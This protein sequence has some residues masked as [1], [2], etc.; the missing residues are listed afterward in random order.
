MSSIPAPKRASSRRSLTTRLP[1]HDG[2]SEPLAV[3]MPG[4]KGKGRAASI[5][6]AEFASRGIERKPLSPK[7]LARRAL[8][9]RK[10]ILKPYNPEETQNYTQGA[11]V[12]QEADEDEDDDDEDENE[13]QFRNMPGESTTM[14]IL[15]RVSFAAHAHVRMF[16]TAHANTL[17]QSQSS[18]TSSVG[19]LPPSSPVLS[20]SNVFDEPAQT[21]TPASSSTRRRSSL[22]HQSATAAEQRPPLRRSRRSSIADFGS[23]GSADMSME[24]E[25]GDTTDF[26]GPP[27]TIHSSL[28]DELPESSLLG[29]AELDFTQVHGAI[30]PS[31]TSGQI[32]SNLPDPLSPSASTLS[33]PSSPDRMPNEGEEQTL[34]FTVATGGIIPAHAPEFAIEGRGSVGYR[35]EEG[36]GERLDAWSQSRENDAAKE[37]ENENVMNLEQD[38][39]HRDDM[40]LTSVVGGIFENTS[41]EDETNT[42]RSSEAEE[43]GG[44]M[45]ETVAFGGLLN[46]HPAFINEAEEADEEFEMDETL[47]LGGVL[48]PTND[49]YSQENGDEDEGIEIEETAA[50]GGVLAPRFLDEQDAEDENSTQRFDQGTDDIDF[51]VAQGGIFEPSADPSSSSFEPVLPSFQPV[52]A[53]SPMKSISS[54]GPTRPRESALT[55]PTLSSTLKSKPN[56]F[57]S[58][59]K[60]TGA[61]PTKKRAL[62]IFTNGGL[63][64]GGLK[65]RASHID[66]AKVFGN[67]GENQEGIQRGAKRRASSGTTGKEFSPPSAGAS[68]TNDVFGMNNL[69][70]APKNAARPA[71]ADTFPIETTP[72][73][74][75]D[76][77]VEEIIERSE[78]NPPSPRKTS[79]AKPTKRPVNLF[80]LSPTSLSSEG[81]SVNVFDGTDTPLL[82][83]VPLSASYSTSPAIEASVF[84]L[85]S[86]TDEGPSSELPLRPTQKYELDIFN[87]PPKAIESA[88]QP[89]IFESLQTL[90]PSSS[91]EQTV[92]SEAAVTAKTS[93]QAD[94]VSP[95]NFQPV[96]NTPR[97][98]IGRPSLAAATLKGK[99]TEET[100][101]VPNIEPTPEIAAPQ[102]SLTQ[103]L[104][105]TNLN[106]RE[107]MSAGKR[108]S[109]IRPGEMLGIHRFNADSTSRSSANGE[110]L[111]M[112]YANHVL[113]LPYL[114]VY[115]WAC[116]HLKDSTSQS[117]KN[118]QV[119]DEEASAR[120]PVLFSEYLEADDQEKVLIEG[121]LKYL[122]MF[123][124]HTVKNKWREWRMDLVDELKASHE[125]DLSQLSQDRTRLQEIKKSFHENVSLVDLQARHAALKAQ[126]AEEKAKVDEVLA[127]DPEVLSHR[128]AEV[129]EQKAQINSL[130]AD[131]TDSSNVL[132]SL[133]AKATALENQKE[134][135]LKAINYAAEYFSGSNVSSAEKAFKLKDEF[136]KIES[137]HSIRLTSRFPD[138]LTFVILGDLELSLACQDERPL[139]TGASLCLIPDERRPSRRNSVLTHHLFELV[140]TSFEGTKFTKASQLFQHVYQL[141][142]SSIR[143]AQEFSL[144]STRYPIVYTYSAESSIEK[145]E[146]TMLVPSAKAKAKVTFTI[147]PQLLLNWPSNIK[148][149]IVD[150]EVCYGQGVQRS[151]LNKTIQNRLSMATQETPT[152]ILVDACLEAVASYDHQQ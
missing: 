72:E 7:K 96:I 127:C 2:P 16:E 117:Q 125:E 147:A 58:P 63:D 137:L 130:K 150:V 42:G 151:S 26:F 79:V 93:S 102:V 60:P 36:E 3:R 107:K 61:S 10:S 20:S 119:L 76:Y 48:A 97:K 133:R 45:D 149:L 25:D 140:K 39:D 35:M 123:A 28:F 88:L 67:F 126:L 142:S 38:Q 1:S 22:N 103:F 32:Q 100:S 112:D 111:T 29:Q 91:T 18:T 8:V 95:V 132:L 131:L 116:N 49:S 70:A 143:I 34:D 75:S 81:L 138:R 6:P 53:K 41:Q 9:P 78:E 98:R 43:E 89:S 108:R 146:V 11:V 134:A 57:D 101:G 71:P 68:Q 40:E 122:K 124:Q 47:P 64:K 80:E 62:P 109:T 65:R 136:D 152:G 17:S 105:L 44:E 141:W 113:N 85:S 120:N 84:P 145:A 69:V 54:I 121:Q 46:P 114:I 74:T 90:L 14:R 129:K 135:C 59:E 99:G 23:D 4:G 12:N 83:S 110:Y 148:T 15:R 104:E 30:L 52:L 37:R 21:P 50:L 139:T 5:G 51:T 115:Q 24:E 55:R 94:A 144:I 73:E 86:Q 128:R 77:V 87:S 13:T 118:V 92:T 56:L 82:P 106:W 19:S 31:H 66:G 27:T 33:P